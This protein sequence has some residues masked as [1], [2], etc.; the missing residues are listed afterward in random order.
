M[1]SYQLTELQHAIVLFTS[2]FEERPSDR[3]QSTVA[4][5]PD[6]QSVFYKRADQPMTDLA[7]D[8]GP[9]PL[10]RARLSNEA[11]KIASLD[12]RSQL[13]NRIQKLL[14]ARERSEIAD[15]D[16]YVM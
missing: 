13:L 9:R 4:Q 15:L 3:D 12:V 10:K 16:M 7:T 5:D 14:S 8:D 11:V 2:S 6:V 1:E